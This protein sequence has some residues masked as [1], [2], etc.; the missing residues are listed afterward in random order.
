MRH[1][2]TFLGFWYDFLVGDDW[3]VA[4]VVLAALAATVGLS[5]AAMPSWWVLPVAILV[6]LPASLWRAQ[7]RRG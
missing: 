2:R 6:V 5:R 7:R 4:A 1:V 3:T